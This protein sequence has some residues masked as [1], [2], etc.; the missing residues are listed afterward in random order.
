MTFALRRA[1]FDGGV[2]KV[3]VIL[4]APDGSHRD[5]ELLD[6]IAGILIMLHLTNN[7]EEQVV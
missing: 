5:L 6:R 2:P 7:N 4:G 1:D 3:H